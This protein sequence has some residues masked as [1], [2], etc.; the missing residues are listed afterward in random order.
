[1][2]WFMVIV[3]IICFIT[4]CDASGRNN[5]VVLRKINI[6]YKLI[7]LARDRQEE[8]VRDASKVMWDEDKISEEKRILRMM[9]EQMTTTKKWRKNWKTFRLMTIDALISLLRPGYEFIVYEKYEQFKSDR[10]YLY[11]GQEYKPKKFSGRR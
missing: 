2:K 11:Y 10:A 5:P 6:F 3:M 8:M 4:P 7:L 1:M 9:Y